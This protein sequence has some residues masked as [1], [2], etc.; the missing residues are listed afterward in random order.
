MNYLCLFLLQTFFSIRSTVLLFLS[1]IF[2]VIVK[3]L[4]KALHFVR[5][6]LLES[7][8]HIFAIDEIFS[9]LALE[10]IVFIHAVV[11]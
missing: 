4:K 2:T 1:N 6:E 10:M 8:I 3:V 9:F 11:F 7:L 5:R